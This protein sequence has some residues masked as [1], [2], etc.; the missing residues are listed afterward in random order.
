MKTFSPITVKMCWI[1]VVWFAWSC[2]N[3]SSWERL[4]KCVA[5]NAWNSSYTKIN[6]KTPTDFAG[7]RNSSSIFTTK[8]ETYLWGFHSGY[9]SRTNNIYRQYT[10]NSSHG[11]NWILTKLMDT[12]VI[13][14]FF[15]GIW[16][17]RWEK[18][19]TAMSVFNAVH[20]EYWIFF[21]LMEMHNKWVRNNKF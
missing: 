11:S 12:T 2:K 18:T 13:R 19:I 14:Y 21:S 6:S 10:V 20:G 16:M 3:L 5:Y 7:D 15:Y 1:P 8:S 4:K 17:L 9:I